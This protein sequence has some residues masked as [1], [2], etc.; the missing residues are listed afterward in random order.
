MAPT[1]EQSTHIDD[2]INT[3][4]VF[5]EVKRS[6]L[7]PNFQLG[8]ITNVF[9]RTTFDF[10]K[11]DINTAVI[12][13]SQVFG[14]VVIKVPPKWRVIDNAS[15]I[16]AVVEDKRKNISFNITNDKI[17]IIKGIGIFGAVKIVDCF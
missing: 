4:A 16:F 9:G 11:A 2:Y 6:V 10:S 3:T 5:G 17:L 7:S 8:Q 13:I 12:D 1:M 14:E 15:N